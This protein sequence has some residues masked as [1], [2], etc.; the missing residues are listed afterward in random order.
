MKLLPSIALVA[1]ILAFAL[2][3]GAAMPTY[4]GLEPQWP[5]GPED[6]AQLFGPVFWPTKNRPKP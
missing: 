6:P 1:L 2:V 4:A 3:A 5:A